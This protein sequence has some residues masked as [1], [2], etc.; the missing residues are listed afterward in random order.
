MTRR[1]VSRLYRLLVPIWLLCAAFFV[2]RSVSSVRHPMPE[3]VFD[4][5]L[6]VQANAMSNAP[7]AFAEWRG[8]RLLAV[9]G[10]PVRDRAELR[11]NLRRPPYELT[12]QPIDG[13][14]PRRVQWIFAPRAPA[15]DLDGDGVVR[16]ARD[17]GGLVGAGLASGDRVLAV[18]GEPWAAGEL[19]RLG[20]FQGAPLRLDVRRGGET[21]AVV[22][23]AFDWRVYAAELAAGLAFG[24]IGLVAFRLR[25]DTLSAWA[26]LW[27]SLCCSALWLAR[28][29]P[30]WSKVPWER[31][32]LL[33]WRLLL[34]VATVYLLLCFSPLRRL[35]WRAS[36]VAATTAA[37]A[38]LLVVWNRW[39]YP[40]IASAGV[41]TG[42]PARVW[43][44]LMLVLVL[45]GITSELWV[46]W[47]GAALPAID[48]QRGHALRL[49]AGAGFLPLTLAWLFGLE[50]RFLWELTALLFPLVLAYTTVRHNIFQVQ[51]LLLEG[52]VYGA[53][54]LGVGF[55]AA[56]LVAGVVPVA[57]ALLGDAQRPWVTFAMVGGATLAA[58]PLHARVRTRLGRRFASSPLD[59]QE[60]ATDVELSTLSVSSP[61]SYCERMLERLAGLI[62]STDVNILVRHPETD[63]WWLAASS[64]R[65]LPGPRLDECEPLFAALVEKQRE[66]ERD[67]LEED[68]TATRG[69][70]R[71]VRA[72]YELG[73]TLAFPLVV[74]GEVWGALTVGDKTD[75]T[76][77]SLGDLRA[78]RRLARECA[79]GLYQAHLLF[80]LGDERS[81]QPVPL[82]DLL[83]RMPQVV[84]P[85][86]LERL[87]GEGGMA[88]VYLAQRDGVPVAVKVLHRSGRFD[89]PL[90][91]RFEREARI[92]ERV[93]H[94][95]VVELLDHGVEPEPYL[96]VE[97]FARGTLRDLLR[98]RRWLGE[99]EAWRLL[100]G[101]AAGL[102]A[103][104]EHGVVHRDVNPRNVFVA[105]DGGVKVGDFGI[106]Q[107][108]GA[109]T[110]T[111]HQQMIGTPGYLSPEACRGSRVDWRSDQYALGV[112]SYEML[113]GKRPFRAA[114]VLEILAMHLHAEVP[115]VRQVRTGISARTAEAIRRMMAK[116]PEERFA[117]YEELRRWHGAT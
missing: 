81:P 96:V 20:G 113:A 68:L 84:G 85:Y 54:L 5:A 74:G 64:R 22:F 30:F 12:L 45:A 48:R 41:L 88:M 17:G 8:D 3:L 102:E 117:S 65:E 110:L 61:R 35:G 59:E 90:L 80:G 75:A 86:R 60:I 58:L 73:A 11:R 114:R 50:P 31:H 32:L 28:A 38:M 62:G 47:A 40:E 27:F 78:M 112:V 4:R 108:D 83:H 39:L 107:W 100:L 51:H 44:L 94:P 2:W 99:D 109:T 25:P 10:V 70:V 43:L 13:A 98:Q 79:L 14:P 72:M 37:V 115:D 105:D 69:E 103:A 67:V 95:R 76:N 21:L 91:A 19:P 106:A 33:G 18:N 57:N 104:L 55:G 7:E 116:R 97:Y 34:P 53:L 111:S 82:G 42:V 71:V 49:A 26:F 92:L 36:R 9:G 101:V 29:V 24:M 16:D 56:G 52:L 87:L 15:V 66:L 6:R 63:A 77:Y 89:A 1:A 23:E 93:R 46:R